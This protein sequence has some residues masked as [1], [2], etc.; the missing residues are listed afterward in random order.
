MCDEGTGQ[1]HF[2]FLTEQNFRQF[3]QLL[4]LDKMLN[5]ARIPGERNIKNHPLSLHSFK[6]TVYL[7]VQ[8]CRKHNI[9]SVPIPGN[10]IYLLGPEF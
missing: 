8:Y 6:I 7:L 3:S 4:L 10:I 2:R 5:P 1:R 9:Q